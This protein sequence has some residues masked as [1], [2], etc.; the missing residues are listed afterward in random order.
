M[1]HPAWTV[2]TDAILVGGTVHP[3]AAGT[4]PTILGT[5]ARDEGVLTLE[6]AVNAMTGAAA[7]RIGLADR[8][9]V[10]PGLAADLVLFDPATVAPRNSYEESR[11]PPAG[12]PWVI[13]N[14][15]PVKA[16]DQP[17]GARPGRVIRGDGTGRSRAA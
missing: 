6:R 2:G 1:R 5:Y 17:T 16:D 14:G 10:R 13:I 3:R 8:G 11:V 12:M 9:L 4:Y 15:V 7:A